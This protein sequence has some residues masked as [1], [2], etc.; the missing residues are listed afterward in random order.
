MR[1]RDVVMPNLN[2]IRGRHF[3][4]RVIKDQLSKGALYVFRSAGS[5]GCIDVLAFYSDRVV[6]IQCKNQAASRKEWGELKAFRNTMSSSFYHVMMCENVGH[7][8]RY[9][10]IEAS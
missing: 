3:E 5:H 1:G 8:L 7:M 2:Y 9:T 4:Y 10:L 6:L